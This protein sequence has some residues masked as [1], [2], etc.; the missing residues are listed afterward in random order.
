MPAQI[1]ESAGD[2]TDARI[3]GGPVVAE[4][5]ANKRV[6]LCVD[7]EECGGWTYDGVYILLYVG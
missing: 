1:L 5:D 3:V 7:G 6:S 2:D 4:G